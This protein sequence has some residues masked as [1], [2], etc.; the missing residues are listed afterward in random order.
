MLSG[1]YL[2]RP[3]GPPPTQTHALGSQPSLDRF[4]A[5]ASCSASR[6]PST[7]RWIGSLCP[8]PWLRASSGTSAW[9]AG[10]GQSPSHWQPLAWTSSA[11]GSPNLGRV[12]GCPIRSTPLAGRF[13]SATEC[14]ASDT[15][16]ALSRSWPGRAWLQPPLPS[17]ARCWHGARRS[18]AYGPY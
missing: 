13:D 10:W 7:P 4:A 5:S 12:N 9:P 16:L 14:D 2:Y 15:G 6:N 3:G 18:L 1:R 17:L 11:R 8:G